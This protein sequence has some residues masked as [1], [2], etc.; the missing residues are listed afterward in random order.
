VNNQ[1]QSKPFSVYEQ[2]FPQLVAKSISLAK[3]EKSNLI[4]VSIPDYAFTPFGGGSTTISSGVEKYNAF[5]KNYCLENNIEF[6]NITDITQQGLKNP[7]LV[8]SDGL[9]PSELAYSKFV[10]RI[11]PKAIA[12]LN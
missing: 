8:A 2:E 5:A 6:V 1:Y 12:I 9:H 11:L 10:E 4:V 7:D 3:G